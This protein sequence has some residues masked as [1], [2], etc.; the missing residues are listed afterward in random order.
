MTGLEGQ[1]LLLFKLRTISPSGISL[2]PGA[3]R[4]SGWTRTLWVAPLPGGHGQCLLKLPYWWCKVGGALLALTFIEKHKHTYG[5]HKA[6]KYRV[7][8]LKLLCAGTAKVF[9]VPMEVEQLLGSPS[10]S[11]SRLWEV[12]WKTCY[13]IQTKVRV[14]SGL[15]EK[16][17]LSTQSK[18]CLCQTSPGKA[19]S[20]IT[21]LVLPQPWTWPGENADCWLVYGTVCVR[22]GGRCWFCNQHLYCSFKLMASCLN[23]GTGV[24]FYSCPCSRINEWNKKWIR[25]WAFT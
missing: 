9:V 13:Q 5:V 21:M 10:A 6:H 16:S 18:V 7:G 4:K 20:N 22:G 17:F 1:V 2:H 8:V 3:S 14:Y 19:E 12:H 25:T 23:L 24:L 11:F 15:A